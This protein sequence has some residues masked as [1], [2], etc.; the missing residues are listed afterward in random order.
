MNVAYVTMKFPVPS[1]TFACTDV[2]ALRQ[3]GV[4]VSVYTMR[5]PLGRAARMLE[6]RGLSDLP[7]SQ[8]TLRADLRGLAAMATR[9]I[10][11]ARL[12]AWIVRVAWRHP[13]HLLKSL[14]LVPR[15]MGILS[16]LQRDRPDVVHL[17]WGH[18]PSLVGF[19]VLDALPTAVLSLFVGTYDLERR[20]DGTG[21]VARRAALVS[22]HA[23]CNF[24]DIEAFG[25]PPGS[26][27]LA[28]R[29]IDPGLFSRERPKVRCRIVTAGR[30]DSDKGMEDVLLTF[31]EI[32][33][34]WP[35]AT[36]RILGDGT[37]RARLERFSAE[38]GLGQSVR[39]LGHVAHHAVADE[40]AEAEV[41]LHLSRSVDD[42]LPNAIKEAMASRCVCIV[43]ETS[44][45]DELVEDRRHG[46]VVSQ[47]NVASAAARVDEVFRRQLDATA[48]SHAASDR[49]SS[50]FN[51]TESMRSYQR[52]WLAAL[53]AHHVGL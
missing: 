40:L 43:T 30:L 36:L 3:S 26:I 19:L 37:E 41:F 48:I 39:F 46:F 49:I 51:V 7:V 47:G 4:G 52:R 42:R 8:G 22:T 28:Y 35:E 50:Q 17:F 34:P 53:D 23:R 13:R 27:H 29:G 31:R 18:Y 11:A 5:R 2:R 33:A 16:E 21:W 1:E 15:S 25:V 44:G 6:E 9:P 20:F 38:L 24:P 10:T 14:T 12:V 32:L 45:I